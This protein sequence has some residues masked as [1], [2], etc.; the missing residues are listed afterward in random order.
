MRLEI[1]HGGMG[2][3]SLRYHRCIVGIQEYPNKNW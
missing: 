2:A 1:T 3:Y